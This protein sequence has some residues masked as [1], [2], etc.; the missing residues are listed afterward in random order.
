MQRSI[1][2]GSII[3]GVSIV[4][5][6]LVAPYQF[7]GGLDAEQNPFVWRANKVTGVLEICSARN[8]IKSKNPFEKFDPSPI[9]PCS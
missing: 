2:I 7:V 4:G 8:V 3:I 9:V 1:L 6:N 5:S